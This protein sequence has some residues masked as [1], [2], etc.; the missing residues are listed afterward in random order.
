[1]AHWRTYFD[2]KYIGAWDL[3]DK[4]DGVTLTIESVGEETVQNPTGAKEKK[5]ILKFK[6]AKKGMVCNKTNAKTIAKVLDQPEIT[7]WVGGEV[8]I[9]ATTCEAF[10][11]PNTECIR[12]KGGK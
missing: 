2:S 7:E 10:G 11:D 5:L 9:Y 6:G 12:V 3:A 1:M 4:P 8:T